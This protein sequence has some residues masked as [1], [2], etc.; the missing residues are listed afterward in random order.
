MYYE[1]F[2]EKTFIV[3]G[4]GSGIGK[5]TASLVLEQG[6]NAAALYLHPPEMLADEIHAKGGECLL[7]SCNV[8]SAGKI[9]TVTE[10]VIEHFGQLDSL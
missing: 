9:N 8:Q 10:R 4:A 3:T 6:A 7:V 5:A 2:W 1:E